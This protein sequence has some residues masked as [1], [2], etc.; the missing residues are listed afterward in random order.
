MKVLKKTNNVDSTDFALMVDSTT[1]MQRLE[2]DKSRIEAALIKEAGC[3]EDIAIDVANIV[4]QKLRDAKLEVVTTSFIRSL[5]NMVLLEKGYDKE[6]KSNSDVTV[7]FYDVTQIIE[8]PN[9]ENGNTTHSPEGINLTLAERVLKEYALNQVFDRD[10]SKA[11]LA[12]E[13]HIHDL[14]MIDR[15][16]CSGHSPEYVKKNGLKNIPAIPNRSKPA[17]SA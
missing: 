7:P 16:Y 10:I 5:V 13:I 15:F 3:T 17:N 6:L 11:H 4:D 8:H 1:D 2:F 14:G 12:G 9:K